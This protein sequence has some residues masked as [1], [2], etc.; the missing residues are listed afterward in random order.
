MKLDTI[1][2]RK[3][4]AIG[5]AVALIGLSGCISTRDSQ[6]PSWWANPHKHDDWYLYFTAEGISAKSY[7]DARLVARESIKSKLVEYI[8]TDMGATNS[9]CQCANVLA[10]HEL[11]TSYGDNEGWVGGTYHVWLMGRYPVSEYVPIR[12]RIEKGQK[13]EK[14]WA[15]TQSA[16]NRQQYDEAEDL[17]QAIIAEYDNILCAPFDLEAVKLALAGV[18]M[19]QGRG[20]KARHW[21]TDVQKCTQDRTWRI[22]ANELFA[23]LPEISPRDAFEGHMVGISCWTRTDRKIESDLLLEQELH[24]RLV[25]SGIQ[26]VVRSKPIPDGR[27]VFDD[28]AI[29][30]IAEAFEIE[31]AEVVFLLILD[32]DYVSPEVQNGILGTNT[33]AEALDAKLT[34]FVVRTTDGL[35]LA[36]DST[37][38][39]S[40]ARAAML[41]TILTHRRHLPS[42]ASAIA[43]NLGAPTH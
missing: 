12:D 25:Q 43:K 2:W 10:L 14:A 33:A 40:R 5:W 13:L 37:V 9:H 27:C 30:R 24:D 11:D 38:G 31:K 4:A 7:E 41:N 1:H 19:Q 16:I 20:L 28:A 23:Q 18:Y 22:R 39:F 15:K 35:V 3:H 32:T 6:V 42:Y 34:Y 21:I 36:S 26:T 8:L 29:K 17:S